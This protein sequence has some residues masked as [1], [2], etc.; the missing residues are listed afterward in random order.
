MAARHRR[1]PLPS[2]SP[3]VGYVFRE[4]VGFLIGSF[5]LITRKVG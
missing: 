4:D 5:N 3:C 2:L 1:A